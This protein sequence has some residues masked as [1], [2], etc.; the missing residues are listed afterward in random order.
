L[1]EEELVRFGIAIAKFWLHIAADE[2]LRRFKDR[3]I[4]PY[5][6]YKITEEDWR[7]RNKWDAYEASACDMI[8]RTSTDLAPWTLIEANDKNWARI[9]VLKTTCER[10]EEALDS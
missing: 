3:E 10:L 8:E 6:Q 4:T 9:K 7:N 1:F 2:Q 5:K